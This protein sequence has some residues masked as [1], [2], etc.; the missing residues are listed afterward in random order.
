MVVARV[1]VGGFGGVN[2]RCY[3]DVMSGHQCVGHFGVGMMER[4]H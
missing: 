1:V 3:T 4:H 2:G